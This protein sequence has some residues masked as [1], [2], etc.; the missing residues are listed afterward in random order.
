MVVYFRS[1]KLQRICGS[2]KESDRAL[3][4]Q[5]GAKLRQRLTEFVAAATLDEISRL[6]PARCHELTGDRAGQ[7][8]VDLKQPYRLLFIPANDPIPRK[9]DGG[10]DWAGITEVEI[11]E[12]ADTH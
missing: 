9:A 2:Q 1:N 4:P 6:P 7:L 5:C 10:L 3:G 11:I 8:S 12:I